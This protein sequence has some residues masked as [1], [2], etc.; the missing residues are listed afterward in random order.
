MQVVCSAGAS[1]PTY[2]AEGLVQSTIE[3]VLTPM[4][5]SALYVGMDYAPALAFFGTGG[6]DEAR[7]TSWCETFAQRLDSPVVSG[8]SA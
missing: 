1:E 2:S 6:A 4:K 7:I 8:Q 3:Q 5:A